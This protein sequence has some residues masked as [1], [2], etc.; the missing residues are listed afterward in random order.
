MTLP[1]LEALMLSL[2]EP[3]YRGAQLYKWLY[4]IGAGSFDEMSNLPQALRERLAAGFS[5]DCLRMVAR[6][7]AKDGT[8]KYLF[9]LQDGLRIETV[10]M[11]EGERSTVCL[12]TQVGCPLGCAFCATGSMGLRRDLLAGEIIEQAIQVRRE[13]PGITNVVFMGM[14]EP[15]LNYEHTLK[16]VRLL[17]DGV[18]IGARRMT[19]STSGVVPGIR[20]LAREGLQVKLAVALNASRDDL[21]NILMPVNRRYPLS[22]LK[23][24]MQ[25]F[26]RATGKL[27]SVE[28][29]LLQ[30]V[31]DSQREAREL[32]Q[33]LRG[34]PCKVNL[35]PYNPVP[36]KEFARPSPERAE[37]F[38]QYLLPHLSSVTLRRSRGRTV[39][40]ACGQLCTRTTSR[41]ARPA[42]RERATISPKIPP[43]PDPSHS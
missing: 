30:G 27:V 18:G 22:V 38:K 19:I 35:I 40:A 7:A 12:S 32:V 17:N 41:R 29:V 39:R 4:A 28:Y 24:A 25:D 13:R 5:P 15:L 9:E 31:N 11:P 34:I 8:A 6:E 36:G 3:K 33:F 1:E 16:A 26:A 14:G 2:G 23:Q 10:Y 21:R 37:R 20:R 43:R 42:L